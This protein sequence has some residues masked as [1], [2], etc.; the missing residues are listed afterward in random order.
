L[1]QRTSD[2]AREI[3]DLIAQSGSQVKAGVD[4]VGRTGSA[5]QEIVA[6]VSKISGLVSEI[7][8]SARNQS[9]GLLEINKAVTVLDQSTQQNAARLEETTAASESLRN[10]AM[11]LVDAICHFKIS[12]VARE[13][14]GVVEP[15][16]HT[17]ETKSSSSQ[18]STSRPR[19]SAPARLLAQNAIAKAETE[20]DDF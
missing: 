18:F 5:L 4:L 9:A 12:Q 17:T 10:D 6:S 15:S 14:G 3:S 16:S 8:V 13:K 7:A 19:K 2:A 1:A 11:G 20:W